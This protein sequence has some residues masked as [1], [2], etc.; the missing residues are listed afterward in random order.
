VCPVRLRRGEVSATGASR[1]FL[2]SK[3]HGATADLG[4]DVRSALTGGARC[5]TPAATSAPYYDQRRKD[6][7]GAVVIRIARY[8]LSERRA[9][10]E[11]PD[12]RPVGDLPDEI[13]NTVACE[14]SLHGVTSLQQVADRSKRELLA[15][16]G[17]GFK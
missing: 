10:A 6:R 7:P 1:P 15:I 11:T 4:P 8:E 3:P 2:P 9:M 16:H 13:G 14:V 5:S 12:F 17:G